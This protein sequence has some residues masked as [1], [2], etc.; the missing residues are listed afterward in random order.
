MKLRAH[1]PERRRRG[2]TLAAHGC[3]CCCCCC[4]HTLGGLIGAAVGST[5]APTPE[6]RRTVKAYWLLFLASTV[7][8]VIGFMSQNRGELGISL[9]VTFICL[10]AAQLNASFMTLLVGLFKPLDL[11]TL[12]R[13]T[14]KAFFWG[15]IGFIVMAV[16]VLALSFT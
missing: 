8:G 2:V 10:P 12:G 7:L 13:I 16:P 6:A 1:P 3:C 14:W 5:K 9:L 15:L 4:L 11:P